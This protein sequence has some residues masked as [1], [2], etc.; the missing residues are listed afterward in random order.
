MREHPQCFFRQRADAEVVAVD[1]CGGDA[2][3]VANI[4]HAPRRQ[5]A[6]DAAV[7]VPEVRQPAAVVGEQPRGERE[8]ADGALERVGHRIA[9]DSRDDERERVEIECVAMVMRRPLAVTAVGGDLP[10]DFVDEHTTPDRLATG[11]RR[12]LGQRAAGDVQRERLT[13]QMRVRTE[14]VRQV[15]LD[16]RQ[17][18]V[19]AEQQID[20]PRRR[21]FAVGIDEEVKRPQPRQGSQRELEHARPVHA[22]QGRIAFE[23][24]RELVETMVSVLRLTSQPVR[25]AQHQPVLVPIQLP[26]DLVVA[27]G[28]IQVWHAG[29]EDVRRAPI[30]NRV[31]VPFESSPT[32]EAEAAIAKQVVVPRQHT[33]GTRGCL[34]R[35]RRELAHDPFD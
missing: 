8:T 2:E 4:I 17:L 6:Q 20:R 3:A 28:G 9:R 33:I 18:T 19:D 5:G 11:A 30:V 15:A 7:V 32:V 13:E 34:R 27:A 10:F 23:P 26:D 21:V 24:A 1:E 16:V 25:A 29:P 22:E 31:V 14:V 12:E 35:A